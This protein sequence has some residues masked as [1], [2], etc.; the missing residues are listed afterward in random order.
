MK[1]KLKNQEMCFMSLK[2]VEDTYTY[3]THK[4]GGIEITV[5]EWVLNSS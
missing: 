5:G 1:W 4:I 3:S 2:V